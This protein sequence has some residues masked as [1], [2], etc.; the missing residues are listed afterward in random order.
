M[1]DAERLTLASRDDLEQAIAF[2][3]CFRVRKRVRN[4][5]E[6]M[7]T[8][9][10]ERIVEHLGE[11]GFIVMRKP[12]S[13]GAAALRPRIGARDGAKRSAPS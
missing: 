3:L 12:P 6:I 9:A 11:S 8:I 1:T 2:A 7:A 5:N 4:V 13:V 10:A